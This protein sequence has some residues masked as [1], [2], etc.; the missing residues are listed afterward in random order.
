MKL[1]S[2]NFNIFIIKFFMELGLQN[3]PTRGEALNPR[4]EALNPRAV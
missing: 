2:L 4:G 1:K 3:A